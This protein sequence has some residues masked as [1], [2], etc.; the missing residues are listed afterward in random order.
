MEF[1]AAL[2]VPFK[3]GYEKVDIE[4]ERMSH[5]MFQGVVCKLVKTTSCLHR[6]GEILKIG[7]QRRECRSEKRRR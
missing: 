2:L 6:C 3:S 4:I 5:Q 1:A 7:R